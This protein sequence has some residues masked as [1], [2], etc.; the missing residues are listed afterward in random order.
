MTP[1][2]TERNDMNED[3]NANVDEE[4]GEIYT[5]GGDAY[6]ADDIETPSE[7][8]IVAAVDL[9]HPDLLAQLSDSGTLSKYVWKG[10]IGGK[11]H[12]GV[13]A[14][15]LN[16]IS[17]ILGIATEVTE[18]KALDDRYVAT[19]T[20]TF[21]TPD[22]KTITRSGAAEQMFKDSKGKNDPFALAK[23]F[24]K[25]QR[26]AQNHLIPTPFKVGIIRA[27]RQAEANHNGRRSQQETSQSRRGRVR[28]D[29]QTKSDNSEGYSEETLRQR[30]SKR[31][32]TEAAKRA[33]ESRTARAVKT[34]QANKDH[35]DD[36]P[37]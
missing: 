33:G 17:T 19:A 9:H 25:A 14:A 32:E 18:W 1:D 30:P 4:T 11:E 13:S 35:G 36:M 37:F 23:V 16:D 22:G 8:A 2:A 5:D 27:Y 15:C 10:K 29:I 7:N 12:L 28:P 6:A 3:R 26:N 21:T 34:A 31:A 24:T 20:A